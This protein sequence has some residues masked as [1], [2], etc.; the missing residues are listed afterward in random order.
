MNVWRRTSPGTD[1]RRH[2]DEGRVVIVSGP[3]QSTRDTPPRPIRPARGVAFSGEVKWLDVG[4]SGSFPIAA[5]TH[6]GVRA[7]EESL[8]SR[9]ALLVTSSA[10]S[11]VPRC[12]TAEG[13]ASTARI[14]WSRRKRRSTTSI[15]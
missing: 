7:I 11:S 13:V 4:T 6:S 3:S 9:P 10:R 12:A 15:R 5:A 8:Y 14:R 1:A 2:R